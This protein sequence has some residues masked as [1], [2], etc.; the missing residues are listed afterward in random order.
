VLDDGV[1]GSL[2][3]ER[4]AAVL[5]PKVAGA[6]NLHR[7]TE[8]L[9]GFVVFSSVSGVVGSAGQANY[10]AGNVFLDGLVASRRARGL[11]GV[12]VAW[13]P[14]APLEGQSGMT[15]SLD[16]A[17]LAR[18]VLPPLSVGQGLDL[19]DQAVTGAGG[20]V[21]AT[22]LNRRPGG[23]VAPILRGL[24]RAPRRVATGRA[25]SGDLASH[26]TALQPQEQISYLTELVRGHAA[27]VLGHASADGVGAD[28]EFRQLGF[29]SLTAIELRN[30]LSSTT[31]I[32]LP[33]TLIFDYPTPATLADYLLGELLGAS[34]Q[35][36][37]DGLSV[38]T[39]LGRLET[40]LTARQPDEAT[41]AGIALRLRQLLARLGASG[42]DTTT[43]APASERLSSASTAEVLA[44]IDN[45]LGHGTTN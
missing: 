38:L 10:A 40:A 1:I 2:T 9:A 29:D 34:N 31:G 8:G 33:A 25:R 16:E 6:W 13:G 27:V 42:A 37:D 18:S 36:E 23:P 26:L 28:K 14:W 3:P 35:A 45:E 7:A 11:A 44:F 5:A 21:V 20:L 17:R 24:V 39:E 22:R 30:S 12:S 41:Q 32:A 43:A 15:G 19:F 4:V